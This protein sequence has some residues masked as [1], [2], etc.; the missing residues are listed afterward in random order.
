MYEAEP[1]TRLSDT[2]LAF[3]PRFPCAEHAFG[4]PD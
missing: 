4:K 3:Q 2:S 1:R